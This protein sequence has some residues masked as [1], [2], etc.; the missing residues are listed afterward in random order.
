MKFIAPK[1]LVSALSNAELSFPIVFIEPQL[2]TIRKAATNTVQCYGTFIA[3]LA[4][5]KNNIPDLKSSLRHRKQ[6]PNLFM[7]QLPTAAC[8]E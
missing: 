3:P 5:E 6:I 8:S 1:V 4:T 2:I 7:A